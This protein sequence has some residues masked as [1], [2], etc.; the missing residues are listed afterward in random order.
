[1]SHPLENVIRQADGFVLIGDSSAA[2]FPG[3]SFHSYTKVGKR[4]Y[5]IDL[6]GMTESRGMTKGAKVYTSVDELPDDRDDLAVIW[7]TR[8]KLITAIDTAVEAGCKRVWFSFKSS[9][10]KS[11]AYAR[12]KGLEVVEVGRCPVY[13]MDKMSAICKAHT[14]MF[15][16]GGGYK[17][18]PQTEHVEK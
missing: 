18:P 1:M 10:T 3:M 2:R 9:D 16:M 11:V 17:K 4:F 5:C 12:E 6:G 8:S 13:Y 14:L 15:K 7:V